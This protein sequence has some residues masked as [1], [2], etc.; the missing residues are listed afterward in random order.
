M[1]KIIEKIKKIWWRCPIELKEWEWAILSVIPGHI[2]ETVR[3]R[4]L[5]RYFKKCGRNLKLADHVTMHNPHL[6]SLGNDVMIVKNVFINAGGGVEIGDNTAIGPYSK[7]WSVNHNFGSLDIRIMDQG[8][9]RAPVKIGNDVW[10][11]GGVII[12]P[13]VTIGNHSVI[14]AGS[15]I[16][17]SVP[18]YSIVVGNPGRIIGKRKKTSNAKQAK[19]TP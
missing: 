1:S 12:L 14:G 9:T 15:V 6:L 18:P 4:I 10:V 3:R 8:W 7:I 11:A 2:G 17:K 19:T 13:G 16:P 5:K